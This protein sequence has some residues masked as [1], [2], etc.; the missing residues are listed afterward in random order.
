MKQV[1][2]LVVASRLLAWVATCMLTVG[3]GAQQ[4]AAES[5]FEPF[6]VYID[7]EAVVAR[8]GPGG[9]Y[10]RT[11][12]LR[13]GQRLEVYLETEQG[14]LGVR[15]P[16]GSFSWIPAD[17]VEVDRSGK[18]GKVTEE[19]TL[20]WIGTHLGKARKYM[21]QVQLAEG[22]TVAILGQAEREGP[23]GPQL[24]YRIAPPAGEFRWVH[25]DQV[26]DDPELLLRDKP[27][28]DDRVAQS[29]LNLAAPDQAEVAASEVNQPAPERAPRSILRP[30]NA[31]PME[32]SDSFRSPSAPAVGDVAL[33][34]L[35]A[36]EAIPLNEQTPLADWPVRESPGIDPLTAVK[37][38]AAGALG[39]APSDAG[40]APER[41]QSAAAART[42]PAPQP[43]SYA[44]P[45]YEQPVGSGVARAIQPPLV[46]IA[47]QP[48]VRSIGAAGWNDT[49]AVQAASGSEWVSGNPRVAS[50]A[51]SPALRPSFP[52]VDYSHLSLDSLQLELSRRMV[53][54]AR[55][56]DVEGLRLAA[57]NLVA[58]AASETERQR[59]VH[60]AQRVRQYQSIASRR[61][62]DPL[63]IP[64]LTPA[65]GNVIPAMAVSP[66][67]GQV[68]FAGAGTS[69]PEVSGYLVQVYSARPESPP[70]AL[71][72]ASG[73]TTHYVSPT[74]GFN[75]RRFLNQHVIVAGQAGYDTGLDTPHIIAS[76]A[77]RSP[78]PR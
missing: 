72:D 48:M 23:D 10:Y 14:W 29:G 31:P 19:G 53:A 77:V 27:R 59:A 30:R 34:T 55:V 41:S 6:D 1:I 50:P 47:S 66:P 39:R 35:E 58:T 15:P 76:T 54:S 42:L 8:C 68:D 57:D 32:A 67:P 49:S 60:L 45:N 7:Q 52:A 16:E 24:W 25:R 65:V 9:D 28:R 13:H 38:L 4:P 5:G 22:E 74:P 75:L 26:V 11:D 33:T 78:E 36:P 21:W 18:I 56:A 46:S 3:A 12:P 44:Q 20:S 37:F 64:E 73:R 40:A 71:T 62:G 17:S 2:G 70:F 61:D 51:V 69:Q 63:P 43:S